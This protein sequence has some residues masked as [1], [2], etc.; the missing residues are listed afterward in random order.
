MSGIKSNQNRLTESRLSETGPVDKCLR[1]IGRHQRCDA[2]RSSRRRH[3]HHKRNERNC[4]RR[5]PETAVAGAERFPADRDA[6]DGRPKDES[7][8]DRVDDGVEGGRGRGGGRW[9]VDDVDDSGDDRAALAVFID[10]FTLFHFLA[11]GPT[12]RAFRR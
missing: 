2:R 9:G 11:F 1:S 6:I 12:D 5:D 3:T 10:T 8:D 7:D 4:R